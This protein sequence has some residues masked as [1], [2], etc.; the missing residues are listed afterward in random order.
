MKTTNSMPEICELGI[1]IVSAPFQEGH[2]YCVAEL[3][4][5]NG[6][7][8]LGD[9]VCEVSIS[10][11]TISID[12]E[13]LEAVPGSRHGEPRRPNAT[14]IDRTI[15][16]TNAAGKSYKAAADAYL[17]TTIPVLTASAQGGISGSTARETALIVND[18]DE[19]LRVRAIPSLRWEV[20]EPDGAPLSGTY[21]GGESLLGLAKA[22]R[23]NRSSLSVN[24]RVRQR[25]LNVRQVMTGASSLIFFSRICNTQRRLLDIFI[26]KSLSAAVSGGGKYLGEIILSNHSDEI[27]DE[28]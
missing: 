7:I 22:E 2:L 28:E 3:R 20:S 27:Q 9:E 6:E 16:H 8:P 24:V 13:G 21:L 14:R 19:H 25:D 18:Q 23:A 11:L 15:T 1:R 5:H 4:L 26:A 12:L 10:K 17:N